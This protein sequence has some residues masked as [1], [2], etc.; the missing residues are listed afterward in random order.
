MSFT[1]SELRGAA[2]AALDRQY[3][4]IGTWFAWFAWRPVRCL[5]KASD[6]SNSWVWLRWV[7]RRQ[8]RVSGAPTMLFFQHRRWPR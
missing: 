7:Q 8:I 3:V 5:R 4:P 6:P 1:K 2:D